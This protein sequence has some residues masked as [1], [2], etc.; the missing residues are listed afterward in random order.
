TPLPTPTPLFPEPAVVPVPDDATAHLRWVRLELNGVSFLTPAG[1]QPG[2]GSPWVVEQY[3][4]PC[5]GGRW[6]Y[7]I[8]RVHNGAVVARFD[9]P[10]ARFRVRGQPPTHN[11]TR[12][13]V[14]MLGSVAGS[15]AGGG[16]T[17]T[18]PSPTPPACESWDGFGPPPR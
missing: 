8:V 6:P 15:W 10:E 5:R 3:V 9:W 7:T 17:A 16:E 11:E 12:A 2:Y 4:D 18:S 1:P 13:L 14:H